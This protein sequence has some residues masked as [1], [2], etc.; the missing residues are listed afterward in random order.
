METIGTAIIPDDRVPQYWLEEDKGKG[1]K[2]TYHV[3]GRDGSRRTFYNKEGR[4]QASLMVIAMNEA[5]KAGYEAGY[6][7]CEFKDRGSSH[8]T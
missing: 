4:Y 8:G 6:R 1:Q 7:S 3:V 5:Y 2:R